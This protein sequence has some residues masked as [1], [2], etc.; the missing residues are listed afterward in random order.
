MVSWVRAHIWVI[1]VAVYALF[2][3]PIW[4]LY[5]FSGEKWFS[6][7]DIISIIGALS[8]VFTQMFLGLPREKEDL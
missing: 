3:F 1:G 8:V 4:Y 2:M 7:V 5:Q 6:Y